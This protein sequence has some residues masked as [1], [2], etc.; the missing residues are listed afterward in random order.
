ML[1]TA[2]VDGAI[3]V[4]DV[5]TDGGNMARSSL[6]IKAVLRTHQRLVSGVAWASGDEFRIASSAH[7][8]MVKVYDIRSSAALQSVKLEAKATCVAWHGG[9]VLSGAA[10]GEVRRHVLK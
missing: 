9:D 6:E 7:D 3:Q 2:H 4:W 5:R 8:E 10:D 1:A